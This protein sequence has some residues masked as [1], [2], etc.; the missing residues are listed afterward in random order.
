MESIASRTLAPY[1]AWESPID[2]TFLGKV[3][4]T[5]PHDQSVQL[6]TRASTNPTG[7]CAV[8]EGFNND[9]E[10]LTFPTQRPDGSLTQGHA[11][12]YVP[13]NPQF[14]ASA[15]TLPPCRIVASTGSPVECSLE[16][17]WAIR[18]YTSRGWSVCVVKS[19]GEPEKVHEHGQDFEQQ[20]ERVIRDCVSVACH[21]GGLPLPWTTKT[22]SEPSPYSPFHLSET[23]GSNGAHTFTLT[24]DTLSIKN[25]L[26]VLA[27]LCLFTLA[28]AL[29]RWNPMMSFIASLGSVLTV[30]FLRAYFYVL[31]GMC[32]PHTETISVLPFLGVTLTTHRGPGIRGLS[33]LDRTEN[34][35]IP[36]DTI[37]DFV[38]VEGIQRWQIVDYAAL[39][40]RSPGCLEREKIRVVFPHLFPN[41]SAYV[42]VYRRL[43]GVLF[44]QKINH[45]ARVNPAKI[46]I[47]GHSQGGWAVLGALRKYPG[48][49]CAGYCDD[50]LCNTA[51]C[52]TKLHKSES[53]TPKVLCKPISTN[54]EQV[55]L[56]LCQGNQDKTASPIT[57]A[58]RTYGGSIQMI[59]GLSC[60][61]DDLRCAARIQAL[62]AEA[63]HLAR[64][65][66]VVEPWSD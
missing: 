12:F 41:V 54:P 33:F 24:R 45:S 21:L 38:M 53:Q 58:V 32:L 20:R 59:E 52:D 63:R 23:L 3:A 13:Q 26:L 50:G 30:V 37:L 14:Q 27:T 65:A 48:I 56:L 49:F 31:S 28:I 2:E 44:G 4:V 43:H 39:L 35:F 36:R 40:T 5:V 46:C 18:Y 19:E 34:I 61:R 55:P 25:D 66:G 57:E 42:H 7:F 62:R 9:P 22:R 6:P 17:V 64:A 11:L 51:H 60:K 29:P 8:P 47:S 10:M 16:C 15:D 1:G